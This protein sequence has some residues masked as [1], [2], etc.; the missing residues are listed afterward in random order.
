M[1]RQVCNEAGTETGAGQA[2]ILMCRW[3]GRY[4][5]KLMQRQAQDKQVYHQMFRRTVRY[6]AKLVQTETGRYPYVQIDRQVYNQ[7]GR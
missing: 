2:G 5:T 3:T 4:V 1:D 7:T 6:T